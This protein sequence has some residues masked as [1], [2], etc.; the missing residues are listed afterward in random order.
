MLRRIKSHAVRVMELRKV[1]ATTVL[2][3]SVP[4]CPMFFAIIKQLGVV[5]APS[6]ISTAAISATPKFSLAATGKNIAG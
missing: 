3:V 5:G 2:E 6:I 1:V 4:S